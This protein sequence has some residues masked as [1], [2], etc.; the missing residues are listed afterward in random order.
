MSSAPTKLIPR[1]KA[2]T[3]IAGTFAA[4]FVALLVTAAASVAHANSDVTRV[5]TRTI[6]VID[7]GKDVVVEADLAPGKSDQLIRVDGTYLHMDLDTQ[8]VKELGWKVS[9]RP[10]DPQSPIQVYDLSPVK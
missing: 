3:I 10:I 2:V 5:P 7:S 8:S 6:L 1:R 9:K 4:I